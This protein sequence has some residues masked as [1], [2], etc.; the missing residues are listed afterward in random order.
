MNALVAYESMYG[1][2]AT[3]GEAIAASLRRNGLEVEAGPISTIEPSRAGG[4]E[5]LVVGGPTHAHGMS[6]KATRKSAVEDQKNPYPEPTATPGLRE[7]MNALPSGSGRPA[8]AFDTRFDKPRLLTGSAAK[9][10][11]RRLERRGYQLLVPAESFFVT[12]ENR[13]ADGQEAH[14]DAWAADL[15][16]RASTPTA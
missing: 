14:A 12:T 2:T 9:G 5:L 1:N 10:M 16:L 11:S 6:S 8:A 3:I 13:L 7:W 4:F 15:A